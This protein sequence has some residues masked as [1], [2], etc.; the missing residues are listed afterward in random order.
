MTKPQICITFL[1]CLLSQIISA[2][3]ARQFDLG[4]EASDSEIAAWDID[5]RTDGKGLPPGKGS[6]EEGRKVYQL[7]CQMCHG[8]NGQGGP[9]DRLV[10]R[11]DNDTF[12]F[13]EQGAPKKTIGNYWPWATTLFDYIR[14]TMPYA[15]PGSLA[16]NE[17]YAVTAYLLHANGIIPEDMTLHA[18]NLP[19]IEMPAQHRFVPDNRTET[20]TVR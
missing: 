2:D 16:D 6:V 18:G 13:A 1:F 19:E 4:T 5:V 3:S 7:Q 10:G 17:V 14:R 8:E 11:I 20:N 9:N 12:P 15:I